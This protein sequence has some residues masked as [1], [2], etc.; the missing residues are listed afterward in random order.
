MA[1]LRLPP[2]S[3]LLPPPPPSTFRLP[4]SSL[5][6]IFFSF[7]S[8]PSTLLHLFPSLS[9]LPLLPL[10]FSLFSLPS[11]TTVAS[12]FLLPFS[13]SRSPLPSSL[14]P[15]ILLSLS[16]DPPHWLLLRATGLGFRLSSAGMVSQR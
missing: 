15:L 8:P 1:S 5:L 7:L 3:S 6:A 11:L 16:S 10:L 12:S 9:L 2:P 13:S 4:A 14:S